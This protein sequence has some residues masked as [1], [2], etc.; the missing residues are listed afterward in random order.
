[1]TVN[2]L[3]FSVAL[4]HLENALN[5]IIKDNNF[6]VYSM[7]LTSAERKKTIKLNSAISLF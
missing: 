3:H 2:W 1:V 4:I 6:P 5:K 7:A